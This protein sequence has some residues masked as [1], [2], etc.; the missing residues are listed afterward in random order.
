MCKAM[1]AN[2]AVYHVLCLS[3]HAFPTNYCFK[4]CLV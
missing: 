3:K 1:E 4:N 2:L